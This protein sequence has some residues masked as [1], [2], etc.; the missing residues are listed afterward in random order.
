MSEL[1]DGP[2]DE[3]DEVDGLLASLTD[4]D[5]YRD[6][7]PTMPADVEDLIEG[8]IPPPAPPSSG[9]GTR[10]A[11]PPPLPGT[12]IAK[13]T[14]PRP[15][16]LTRT[17]RPALPSASKPPAEAKTEPPDRA[18]FE[19]V[20][21]SAMATARPPLVAPA[22]QVTVRPAP[23]GPP[24]TARPA[25][26]GV[27]TARPAPVAPA[28]ATTRPVPRPARRFQGA[29]QIDESDI[30]AALLP[31]S[32]PPVEPSTRPATVPGPRPAVNSARPASPPVSQRAPSSA[33]WRATPAPPATGV[34]EPSALAGEEHL[35]ERAAES[36]LPPDVGNE[37][38]DELDAVEVPNLEPPPPPAIAQPNRSLSA[39]PPDGD[40]ESDG[41]TRTFVEE[42]PPAPPPRVEE[43][44]APPLRNESQFEEW[45]DEAVTSLRVP[46]SE[47][48]GVPSFDGELADASVDYTSATLDELGVLSDPDAAA[49]LDDNRKSAP[50]DAPRYFSELR[51]V[52]D[53]LRDHRMTEAWIARAEWFEAEAQTAAD[54]SARGR[55]LLA[56]SELWAMASNVSRAREVAIRAAQAAPQLA[57]ASR[58]A[59]WLSAVDGDWK[60]VAT[61]LDAEAKTSTSD[62][63]RGHAAYLAAEIHRLVLGDAEAA[64]KKLALLERTLPGDPRPYAM[65]LAL[66][67]K[68]RPEAPAL[69]PLVRAGTD[70]AHLRGAPHDDE[71]PS[72]ALAFEDARRALAHRDREKAGAALGALRTVPGIGDGSL[73]LA[74]ALLAPGKETRKD[75]IQSLRELLERAP[76]RAVRRALAA[77]ALEQ[78]DTDAMT[79]ALADQPDGDPA[80]DAK[81]RVAL[82]ALSGEA[83]DVL[84]AA[85]AELANDDTLRPLAAAATS[86]TEPGRAV[87]LGD[88]ET[89][90]R[91][92]LG[93]RLATV[94]VPEEL[95]DALHALRAATP[96][97]ML[98]RVLSLELD[99]AASATSAVAAE[100]TRLFPSEQA[101]ESKLAA[102]LTEEASGHLDIARRH[103][104]GAL[105]SLSVAEAAVRALVQQEAAGGDLIAT[106]ANFFGDESTTRKALLLFEAC[107]RTGVDDKDGTEDLLVRAHEAAPDVPLAARLG[108]DLARA[109]GDVSGLLAWLRRRREHARDPIARA[110]DLV[111]EA[112]LSADDHPAD[113]A[114]RVA[115]A[116]EA[117]PDDVALRELSERLDPS[118][119]PERAKWREQ[120]AAEAVD[121]RTK[122]WLYLE[123]SAEHERDGDLD[124]ARA[125]ASAAAVAAGSE[126]A[127][128]ASERLL[129]G[130]R[131]P[132][133]EGLFALR[134]REQ[135]AFA[136][137]HVEDVAKIATELVDLP[138]R[139]ESAAHARLAVRLRLKTSPWE[140][141]RELVERAARF[142][143]KSLW[144]LRQRSAHAR[145]AGD[146]AIVAETERELADRTGRPV[147]AGTLALRA[148]EA[149]SRLG[150][151]REALAL[152]GRTI[153]AVSDHLVARALR[154]DI[155][156][157]LGDAAAAAE[158]LEALARACVGRDYQWDAWYRAGVLF[159]DHAGN[160]DRALAAFEQAGAID[161]VKLDL[162]DRLQLLYVQRSDR[163]KLAAL[164]ERR[165][166][167]TTDPEE[168]IALEV[169]RGRALADVG[170]R[171]AARKALG[172]ALEADPDHADALEVYA[173]L[174]AADGDYAQAEES[175][176]RLARIFADPEK[177]VH[178]YRKLAALYVEALPNIE[179][180]ELCYREILKR[181]PDDPA[182]TDGLV[183]VYVRSGD[184]TNA[185][186]L[187]TELLD[188]A[189]NN[190]E[191]RDR[192]LVLSR[193]YEDAKKDK[194]SAAGILDR[195]RKTW[196]HDSA[197]LK[198]VAEFHARHGE[199]AALN[200]LLD[201]AS[202][203]ARRAL[204]HGRFD[205]AF[206]GVLRACAE[207]RGDVDAAKVTAAALDALENR[208]SE[209]LTGAG[210]AA[211]QPDL[212][213]A[214][215]PEL[216]SPSLRAL[217]KRIPGVLDAAFPFDTKGLRAT[218]V[219]NGAVHLAEEMRIVAESVGIRNLDVLVA[220]S[221]GPVFIPAST[222]PPRIV[223]GKALL[224]SEDH[225]GRYFGLF[226]ALKMLQTEAA[227]LTRIPP[228]ELWPALAALLS[229]LAPSYQPQGVD[230][231]KLADARRRIA[232]ALPAHPGEDLATLALEVGG[233]IGNRASQLGQAVGQWGSRTALLAVGN[234]SVALRGIA[235][236]LG[237]P[238]GPPVDL[239][240]RSKWIQR[241]AEAR[242][243]LVFSVGEAYAELRK[244]VGLGG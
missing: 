67:T 146:W 206:F 15:P 127:R 121:P 210:A 150:H 218:P 225:A 169:T 71:A 189:T 62:A 129:G 20:P 5:E 135:E 142:P 195:A 44:S 227:A 77:R 65:K 100:L 18:P 161:I 151:D 162:F 28:S 69:A 203:E 31:L 167:D 2:R 209:P 86:A 192:T 219:P 53:R 149:E 184:A 37:S 196:P 107:V 198:A 10:V 41:P 45:D 122:S 96:N 224:D 171:V 108:G 88:P 82:G 26:A 160:S 186:K 56:A 59:R 174:S 106:L 27:A 172:A 143:E 99:A 229:L 243:V 202:S 154:A 123:A 74:A 239:A 116:I 214:I 199:T 21:K 51:P 7:Q 93:R 136:S 158:D 36:W 156:E 230:A 132:P 32:Q 134:A 120:A 58:Q 23:A 39:S 118:P 223:M 215:A 64:E 185:V 165:L 103:Y 22:A 63:A 200:V 38:L 130:G 19:S 47:D 237:Q 72:A 188:R 24:A 87:A 226:R 157:R 114:A 240:E 244:K 178:V 92:V 128:V 119:S 221:L 197:V 238:E 193:I 48:G 166:A 3:G 236:A 231:A 177:Q 168:R 141:G 70:L 173:S 228:I 50:P 147:D 30:D 89:R 35:A 16:P 117:R 110:L 201:R 204:G 104:A 90:S 52:A 115:E 208:E 14:S 152:L 83:P 159:A 101:A 61:A 216:L 85:V 137:E 29:D 164:L 140:E 205:A 126:L 155:E 183:G 232:S 222:S 49:L 73:F 54:A 170:D 33:P 124:A 182:A 153:G 4:D 213:D 191:K 212:D 17:A 78:G 76:L 81:D 109:R 207:V 97:A 180:A 75:S 9:P 175:W 131:K 112:F 25:P 102:G 43:P 6:P 187:Q 8:S 179:R 95:K 133:L 68:A 1:G 233:A 139:G 13:V 57:L 125:A 66:G 111:R 79:R 138:D 98:G 235:A 91:L 46:P 105:G 211:G 60:A 34:N 11:T 194:K 242:D 80:F 234:P 40:F 84:R 217:L 241:N 55:L 220:P 113:A 145:I 163:E 148:A 190:D 181:K 42:L 12:G 94:A 144:T 176:I